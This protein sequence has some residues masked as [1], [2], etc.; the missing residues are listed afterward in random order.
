MTCVKTIRAPHDKQKQLYNTY[1]TTNNNDINN[2][3]K[4][5][6]ESSRDENILPKQSIWQFQSMRNKGFIPS[7]WKVKQVLLNVNLHLFT[8]AFKSP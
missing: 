3:I 2:R 8:L 6:F 1:T 7:S 4:D 5:L